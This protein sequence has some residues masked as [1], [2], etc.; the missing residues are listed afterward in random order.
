MGS[1]VA[2]FARLHIVFVRLHIS[3]VVFT[4]DALMNDEWECARCTLLNAGERKSC[5]A[6]RKRRATCTQSS[7]SQAAPRST[8]AGHRST[9]EHIRETKIQANGKLQDD[10]SSLQE[11]PE[12]LVKCRSLQAESSS[13]AISSIFTKASGG[14]VNI[15]AAAIKKAESR[16]QEA[17]ADDDTPKASSL[18]T[19]AVVANESRSAHDKPGA[20][21]STSFTHRDSVKSSKRRTFI[22]P[23][24]AQDVPS[25]TDRTLEPT[26]L[27]TVQIPRSFVLHADLSPL[28]AHQLLV[29][30]GASSSGAAL[31]WVTQ[32]LLM[33]KWKLGSSATPDAVFDQL[34][35]RYNK[36]FV[37]GQRSCLRRVTEGDAN[38][39]TAMVLALRSVEGSGKMRVTDGWYDVACEV[40]FLVQRWI[41]TA[42]IAPGQKVLVVGSTFEAEEAY[43]PLTGGTGR[44][45]IPFNGFFLADPNA[46]LGFLPTIECPTSPV[47][48][49]APTGGPVSS[50]VV[51]VIR[52]LPCCFVCKDN[53]RRIVRNCAAMRPFED[54]LT[55]GTGKTA[56]TVSRFVTLMVCC[57]HS[58]QHA[59]VQVWDNVDC[60]QHVKG[61]NTLRLFGLT[62][63]KFE[64]KAPFPP[65]KLFNARGTLQIHIVDPTELRR[66][67]TVLEGAS[68]L[69]QQTFV[70]CRGFC[71]CEKQEVDAVLIIFHDET[72]N[73]FGAVM[74]RSQ[75]AGREVTLPR[76]L[77]GSAY[78]FHNL[79]FD[80]YD[81]SKAF[82]FACFTTCEYT[83]IESSKVAE[84]E[85]GY[86]KPSTD[87]VA[88]LA[89]CFDGSP[90]LV[91]RLPLVSAEFQEERKPSVPL[92][93]DD[94][95]F[96]QVVETPTRTLFQPLSSTSGKDHYF[97]N[98]LIRTLCLTTRL[99][100]SGLR[101][102]DT[103]SFYASHEATGFQ[104][105][106]APTTFRCEFKTGDCVIPLILDRVAMMLTAP[107]SAP[108]LSAICSTDR[109]PELHFRRMT[110]LKPQHGVDDLIPRSVVLREDHWHEAQEASDIDAFLGGIGRWNSGFIDVKSVLFWHEEE[111]SAFL[112]TLSTEVSDRLYKVTAMSGEL[113]QCYPLCESTPIDALYT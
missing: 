23:R 45:C 47:S 89:S 75:D 42:T 86:W 112:D 85:E 61:G 15:S 110:A 22:P 18:F 80:R 65:S 62:P 57:V 21:E 24:V 19:K 3:S 88:E 87:V 7:S 63:S 100:D 56:H 36:E 43:S 44:L 54:H 32:Q 84:N 28:Q 107:L 102:F 17:S 41:Q 4:V 69:S 72:K 11:S 35:F 48:R 38:A 73:I 70:D 16:L 108:R 1:P 109:A 49:V 71:L 37:S 93:R 111:W 78:A 29:T 113:H 105:Q 104:L 30:L 51:K 76:V 91:R 5:L 98:F 55:T 97:G 27:T 66:T 20:S 60:I 50:I 12:K 10:E 52:I 26:S 79:V 96:E 58:K 13:P 81:S 94:K 92:R 46:P 40:D 8:S 99:S 9:P 101:L 14:A 53:G 106:T 95:R 103:H 68:A 77:P 83:T 82:D 6:C 31:D 90:S 74:H 67:Y 33:I 34:L 64:L 39:K 59:V 25:T 2:V